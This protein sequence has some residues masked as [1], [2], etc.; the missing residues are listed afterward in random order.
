[1]LQRTLN[2]GNLLNKKSFFLFGPRQTGKSS[3]IMAE[4]NKDNILIIDLLESELYLRLSAN[5]AVLEELID[6]NDDASLIV[7]DE[8][9]LIPSLLNE[10]HRLIEKRHKRFLLTGSSSRKL[11]Q[12]HVN[13]LAGRA[14]EA[15]LFPLTFKEIPDFD[16]QRYLQYGGLPPVYLSEYPEEELHAYVQTY[17]RQEIQVESLVRKIPAFSRFLQG[18][19]NDK[20]TNT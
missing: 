16:L 6:G 19:S 5:P 3:L 2:L 17:L 8:V 15:Q 4:L 1:M 9:Q 14:W 18:C 20:W 11:K 13:L 12:R 7:I 10:V